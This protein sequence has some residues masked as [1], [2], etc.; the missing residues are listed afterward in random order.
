[1]I[2]ADGLFSVGTSD[3][4]R[5]DDPGFDAVQI[6]WLIIE[7]VIADMEIGDQRVFLHRIDHDMMKLLVTLQ[8]M[9][10]APIEEVVRDMEIVSKIGL[11]IGCTVDPEAAVVD[12]IVGD[13]R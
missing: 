5:G 1:M 6:F 4:N 12:V 8:R 7:I 13:H 3:M 2:Y 9:V 10:V 11:G